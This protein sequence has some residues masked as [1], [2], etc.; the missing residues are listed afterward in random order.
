MLYYIRRTRSD[1]S[2]TAYVTGNRDVA[3]K[4]GRERVQTA[5]PISMKNFVAYFKVNKPEVGFKKHPMGALECLDVGE[6]QEY[7]Q[8]ELEISKMGKFA[9]ERAQWEEERKKDLDKLEGRVSD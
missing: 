7:I 2:E 4:L 3:S 6:V 9:P 1:G 8:K 5:V